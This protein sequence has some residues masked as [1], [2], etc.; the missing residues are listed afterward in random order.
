MSG[1]PSG[2][3]I[4]ARTAPSRGCA[5][6]ARWGWA[7]AA[8]HQLLPPLGSERRVQEPRPGLLVRHA[9][10]AEDR[11]D[12]L[13]PVTVVGL[14]EPPPGEDLRHD[15]AKRQGCISIPDRLNRVRLFLSLNTLIRGISRIPG[16]WAMS[17]RS[18]K[19]KLDT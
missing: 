17:R 12:P 7:A 9:E 18:I 11:Q 13:V 1:G 19:A 16:Y 5:R 4:L 10:H 14:K 3:E 8:V 2:L 6:S 15:A